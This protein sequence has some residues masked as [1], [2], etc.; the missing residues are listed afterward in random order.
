[1]E[2]KQYCQS[3][4]EITL[5]QVTL[6]QI[7]NLIDTMRQAY[8]PVLAKALNSLLSVNFT[9]DITNLEVYD[10]L[11]DRC[12][13]RSKGIQ[14][15]L[16]IQENRFTHLREKFEKTGVKPTREYY[17]SILLTLS[18]SAGF[19]MTEDTMTVWEFAERMRRHQD[20]MTKQKQHV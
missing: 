15:Q 14:L 8:S 6:D 16:T 11:L 9:F 19:N 20:K 4:K 17:K 18:D 5:L 3:L 12:R 7:N 1:M 2:Y 13:S 10:T